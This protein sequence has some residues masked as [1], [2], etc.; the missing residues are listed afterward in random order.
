MSTQGLNESEYEE[1]SEFPQKEHQMI[2]DGIAFYCYRNPYSHRSTR[3]PEPGSTDWYVKTPDFLPQ[4][5]WDLPELDSESVGMVNRSQVCQLHYIFV[6]G[7]E[8]IARQK[9]SPD[10][11]AH[12]PI[13]TD[14]EAFLYYR[15]NRILRYRRTWLDTHLMTRAGWDENGDGRGKIVAR[16]DMQYYPSNREIIHQ[17][18]VEEVEEPTQEITTPVVEAQTNTQPKRYHDEN[19]IRQAR[20]HLKSNQ[21]AGRTGKNWLR[22]LIAFGV[23]THDTLTPFT[24][25]EARE[26]VSR[27]GGWRPFAEALE[28]VEAV[29]QSSPPATLEAGVVSEPVAETP[30]DQPVTE[31]SVASIIVRGQPLS[32]EFVSFINK[33]RTDLTYSAEDEENLREK[34]EFLE[35]LSDDVYQLLETEIVENFLGPNLLE[36]S[37]G[38]IKSYLPAEIPA[39]DINQFQFWVHANP[40][41]DH[42]N[43][44]PYPVLKVVEDWMEY[45]DKD[46]NIVSHSDEGV[47]YS[48][49]N[50]NWP[51]DD[52]GMIVHLEWGYTTDSG[53]SIILEEYPIQYDWAGGAFRDYYIRAES[54]ELRVRYK[55]YNNMRLNPDYKA[56]G[57]W[58][59]P[60][61]ITH[62]FE[63]DDTP[64]LPD[65]R[66]TEPYIAIERLRK[67]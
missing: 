30:V 41:P 19:L 25:A 38:F 53:E 3:P 1:W 50:R 29:S 54:G 16:S 61:R 56:T 5:Y 37:M 15:N 51:E 44:L 46:G 9:R 17:E 49:H 62:G 11:H 28:E 42:L 67:E 55:D 21:A 48:L 66:F 57:P 7:G 27:W 34:I 65:S 52:G 13:W 36:T 24:A 8:V 2:E 40:H 20:K 14:D 59:E 58:S 33:L 26:R 64:N 10:E 12:L 39:P 45:Y 6:K 31:E 35:N 63:V 60:K 18:P 23:E 22:I 47:E 43:T 4:W 32:D